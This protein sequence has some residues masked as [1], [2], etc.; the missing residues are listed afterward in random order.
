MTRKDF[1]RIARVFP[2]N[3][4][5]QDASYDTLELWQALLDDTCI[6][7]QE[8]NPRFDEAHFRAACNK[9]Q[10]GVC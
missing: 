1:E 2:I 4:P 3:N 8:M 6:A 9:G 10:Q 5:P 7:L